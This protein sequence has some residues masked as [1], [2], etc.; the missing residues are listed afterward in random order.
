MYKAGF[1]ESYSLINNGQ[2]A[3]GRSLVKAITTGFIY[4]LE[5]KRKKQIEQ[6]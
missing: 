3:I 1:K 6:R 2:T 5:L 4:E